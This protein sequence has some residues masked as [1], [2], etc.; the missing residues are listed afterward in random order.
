MKN[1]YFFTDTQ[2][3]HKSTLYRNTQHEQQKH[4][5]TQETQITNNFDASFFS[6]DESFLSQ[7]MVR[8][9]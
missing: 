4:T 8:T 6:Q 2:T 3:E 1:L 9:D 7:Q 5:K